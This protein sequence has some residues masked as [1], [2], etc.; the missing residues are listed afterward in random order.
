MKEIL[1]EYI[2]A[3][4]EENLIKERKEKLIRQL[5]HSKLPDGSEI[6][7]IVLDNRCYVRELIMENMP[8]DATDDELYIKSHTI[9]DELYFAEYGKHP[10]L[11]AQDNAR[12]GCFGSY[13]NGMSAAEAKAYE[14]RTM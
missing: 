6:A 11:I 14:E 12:F 7:D 5:L 9:R 3:L 10:D 2:T 1:Q 4:R 13:L 8:D